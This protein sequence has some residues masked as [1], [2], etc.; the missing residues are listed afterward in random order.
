MEQLALIPAGECA[1]NELTYHKIRSAIGKR[2]ARVD[3]DGVATGCNDRTSEIRAFEDLLVGGGILK[4]L[5]LAIY[6]SHA[7]KIGANVKVRNCKSLQSCFSIRGTTL[8]CKPHRTEEM[9][10]LVVGSAQNQ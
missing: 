6:F 10:E 8:T 2:R 5:L 1:W 9:H 3:N 7:R 4:G